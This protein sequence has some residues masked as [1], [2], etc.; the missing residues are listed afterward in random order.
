VR[1]SIIGGY[2]YRG[3]EIPA[4]RGRYVFGDFCSGEI[5]T[6]RVAGGR[7]TEMRKEPAEVI[8]LTSF[9]EDARGEIYATSFRTGTVYR[10]VAP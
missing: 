2:V 7:A 6:T 1:G 5:W 4:L 3:R 8:G 10:L 9:G